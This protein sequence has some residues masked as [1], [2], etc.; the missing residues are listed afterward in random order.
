METL[1]FE[2]SE[3]EHFSFSTGSL[4]QPTLQIPIQMAQVLPTN[5]QQC[6]TLPGANGP[7]AAKCCPKELY[8]ETL[9]FENSE[10]EPFSFSTGT[11]GQ[12]TLPG[13]NGP[14]PTNTQQMQHIARG[15]WPWGCTVLPKRALFGDFR[16]LRTLK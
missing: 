15:Q 3:I 12:P 14:G 1:G 4:G 5:T 11:L 8:L 2:N 6:S 13:A 16:G 9:G 7:G 10:I